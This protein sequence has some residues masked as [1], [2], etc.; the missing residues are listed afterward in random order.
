MGKRNKF[1]AAPIRAPT[2]I[3]T[4]C[5]FDYQ[6]DICKDYKETGFCGFGDSCIYLHDRGNT[7][8]GWQLEQ[9]WEKKQRI[10]REEQE[11][12]IT[13]F[14]NRSSNNGGGNNDNG[15]ADDEDAMAAA[16][17]TDDGLP[18]A[19]YLSRKAF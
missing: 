14:M 12:Q 9:V 6:P 10:K 15:T 7:L 18:F 16:T 17:S 19:C 8:A 11:R 4:T 1:L 13:Q 2:N 3:R 5:R